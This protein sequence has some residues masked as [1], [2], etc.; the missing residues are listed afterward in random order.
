M[1]DLSL[2]SPND[3]AQQFRKVSDFLSTNHGCLFHGS[4]L[5]IPTSRQKQVLQ[6]L[7]TSHPGTQRIKLLARTAVY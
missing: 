2:L 1:V 6:V 3:S 5:E 4:R 7:H